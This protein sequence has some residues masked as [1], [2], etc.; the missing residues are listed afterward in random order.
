MSSCIQQTLFGEVNSI[1]VELKVKTKSKDNGKRKVKGWVPKNQPETI[2]E[3]LGLE[4]LPLNQYDWREDYLLLHEK[5]LFESLAPCDG[6]NVSMDYLNEIINW[7]ITPLY[8]DGSDLIQPFSFQACCIASEVD[9]SEM[10]DRIF[11]Q[12]QQ[13]QDDAMRN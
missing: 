3:G 4:T 8:K 9:P 6:G 13:A 1:P 7:V 5:L 2:Q 10:R 12:L 11:P